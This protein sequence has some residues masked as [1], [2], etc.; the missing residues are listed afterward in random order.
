MHACIV[1]C[2]WKGGRGGDRRREIQGREGGR[3]GG[4]GREGER[5]KE[6]GMKEEEKGAR[7]GRRREGGIVMREHEI[8]DTMCQP[9]DTHQ[10]NEF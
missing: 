1:A 3:E 5:G 2:E 7:E 6:G 10:T 4:G 9:L 8:C